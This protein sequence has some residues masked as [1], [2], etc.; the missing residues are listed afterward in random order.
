MKFISVFAI[1][2]TLLSVSCVH[3]ENNNK[4]TGDFVI[5]EDRLTDT[6]TLGTGCFWCTE[7]IFQQLKGVLKV[8]AGYSGGHV[9]NPTYDEVCAKNTGHAEVV[10]VVYDPSIITYD[11]LLQVFWETHDPTTLNRQ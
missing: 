3:K 5:S 1:L 9:P 6:A 10:Q 7:A 8:T 4:M 2:N 11:E